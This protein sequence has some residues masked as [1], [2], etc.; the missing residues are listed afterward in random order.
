MYQY[1]S[2]LYGSRTL[3]APWVEYVA[4][5][6]AAQIKGVLNAMCDRQHAQADPLLYTERSAT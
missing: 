1:L 3:K 5:P 4:K 2:T 6:K